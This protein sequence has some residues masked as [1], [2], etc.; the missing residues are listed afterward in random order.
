LES[1]C[2]VETPDMEVAKVNIIPSVEMVA[3]RGKERAPSE[4]MPRSFIH[5]STPELDTA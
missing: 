1:A 5:T 3:A 2:I 4:G